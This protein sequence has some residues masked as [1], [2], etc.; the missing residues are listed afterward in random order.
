MLQSLTDIQRR[1]S[2]RHRRV[3]P[4]GSKSST[5]RRRSSSGSFDSEVS[6]GGSSSSFHREKR[7]RRFRNNPRDAFKKAR[8]PTFNGEVK[9]GQ[10]VEAWLLGMKKYFP[11][12]RLFRK[13]EGKSSHLQSKW[14]II[15]LVGA[16]QAGEED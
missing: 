15:H 1:M 7:K 9:T 16:P 4:E 14:K 8:S 10:E 13:Y 11:S 5:R 12:P 6:T 2:S 3:K